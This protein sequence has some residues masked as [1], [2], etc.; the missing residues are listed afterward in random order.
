MKIHKK[1]DKNLKIIFELLDIDWRTIPKNHKDDFR[2]A[3]RQIMSDSYIQG[4]HDCA[5]SLLGFKK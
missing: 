4:S 2:D 1:I 5:D 3:M